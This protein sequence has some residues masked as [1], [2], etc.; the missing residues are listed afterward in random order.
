[1]KSSCTIFHFQDMIK[2]ED[3]TGFKQAFHILAYY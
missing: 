2:N 1:M 3:S